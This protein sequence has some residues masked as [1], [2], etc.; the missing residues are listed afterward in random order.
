MAIAFDSSQL[1]QTT[2]S[3]ATFSHTCTGSNLILFVVVG[4]HATTVITSVTY[5]GVGMT[6]VV[7]PLSSPGNNFTEN[8]YYLINPATGAN[9]VVVQVSTSDQIASCSASYTGVSQTGFPDASGTAG[10]TSVVGSFTQSL[11]TV[12]NNCW[13][14][15]GA[16]SGESH[17]A[18]ANTDIREDDQLYYGV[19]I[20]D[21][22][23]AQ[24]P[25]GVSHSMNVT[26][27]PTN[28]L[29]IM[30]SFAP[31]GASTSVSSV[32]GI[33]IASVSVVEGVPNANAAIIEGIVN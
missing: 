12:A 18:G 26:G 20:A 10:P 3:S 23:S 19:F 29:G 25:G 15:W 4:T 21:T 2:N 24:T 32:E 5:N 14:V 27:A 17:T 33:P 28:W 31:A 7:G 22:N 11:T 16:Y 6:S 9:N 8:L 13:M 30:A 1:N